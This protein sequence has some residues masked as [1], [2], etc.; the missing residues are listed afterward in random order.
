MGIIYRLFIGV[1]AITLCL[2]F[3]ALLAHYPIVLVIPVVAFFLYA[4]YQLGEIVI[5]IINGDL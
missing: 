5:S 4:L 2:S 1:V 3:V